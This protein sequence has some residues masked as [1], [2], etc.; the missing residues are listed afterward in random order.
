MS[1]VIGVVTG[2]HS[3]VAVATGGLLFALAVLVHEAGHVVAYRALAPLD[4][5][6]IF[7]VRGMRCH[8]VRMRLVPVSDGAVALAGPLAPAAMAIFFVPL[9]FADRVAPW[10]PLVCFAWLALALSHALCA[11][12]PFGDG[13]TIRESWSLA[14]AERSTR[15]RSSTT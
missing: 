13:T 12:L 9:L 14:R 8:L 2:L 7:V 15:Q 6:A 4:A 11:A 3:L 5:P 10:L 1:L